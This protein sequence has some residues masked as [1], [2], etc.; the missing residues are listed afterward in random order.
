MLR[1][2]IRYLILLGFSIL[3]Y[4]FYVGYASWFLF[5][6]VC[7]LP[8]LSYLFFRLARRKFTIE[9]QCDTRYHKGD[10]AI[11]ALLSR[12]KNIIPLACAKV[13]YTICN[14]FY[15]EERKGMVKLTSEYAFTEVE[16][17]IDTQRCGRI[18]VSF[19]EVDLYDFLGLF[20][21][22][23][24]MRCLKTL[25]VLP[26]KGNW[27]EPVLLGNPHE[28]E[29]NGSRILG[30]QTGDTFDVHAYRPGDSLHRVHW[31]LSAKMDEVMVR[32]FATHHRNQA[33]IYFE[34]YG[35]RNDCEVILSNV[36][37]FSIYLLKE[38]HTHEIGQYANGNCLWK[39]RISTKQQLDQCMERIL[40]NAC[41]CVRELSDVKALASDT[42]FFMRK[43]GLWKERE[44]GNRH[45]TE[46]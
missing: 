34:F 13:E 18:D 11:M 36:Y 3:L 31:K 35:S 30:N 9:L 39:M 44:R 14:H 38:G 5:A 41:T 16:L 10:Q 23:K 46:A 32:E 42:I 6:L 12:T 15:H 27:E 21:K 24:K 25:Y 2:W 29:G 20:H 7:T 43:D 1:C 28:D 33:A 40:S 4:I 37:H 22:K 8:L 19:D 26:K 45:G 17:P